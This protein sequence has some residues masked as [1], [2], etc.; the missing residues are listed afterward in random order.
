MKTYTA[1]QMKEAEL[2]AVERGVSFEELMERAGG[3]AAQGILEL[4]KGKPQ[5]VLFICGKGNNAGDAL[6]VARRLLTNGW[7]AALCF[8]CGRNLSELARLNLQRLEPWNVPVLESLG[9]V[10]AKLIA[11]ADFIVDGVFGTGFSGPLPE[12][13]RE[14][15]RIANQTSAVRVA[16]DIPSGM[17]CD[18]G[19]CDPDTFCAGHTYTF[20]AYK[21]AHIMEECKKLCG[22]VSCIDIGLQL[23]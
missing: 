17:N 11:Q 19:E 1:K 2:L 3:G 23:I 6:V 12:N 18:T 8:L 20:G 14:V 9:P 22:N 10:L 4:S 21:K 15:F 16:L 7:D 5:R 13:C